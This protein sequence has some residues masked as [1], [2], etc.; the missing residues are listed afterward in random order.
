MVRYFLYSRKCRPRYCYRP[1]CCCRQRY[2]Y[3]YCWYQQRQL[4]EVCS[5][6]SRIVSPFTKKKILWHSHVAR[7]PVF[8]VSDNARH[9]PGCTG[10][11]M[12]RG[13]K[14]RSYEVSCY[15]YVAKIKALIS[16]TVTAQLISAF[17]FFIFKRQV[18]SGRGSII[19]NMY[20]DI[21]CHLFSSP[22]P[23][24]Y[25]LA[26]YI[27]MLW[28]PSLLLLSSTIFKHIFLRNSM[29]N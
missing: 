28:R 1:R 21:Y 15:I 11:M 23:K 19:T 16:C 10:H 5:Q 27:P 4:P 2:C 12:A 7:K 22:E 17:V 13:L 8:G 26:Y 24:A 20:N 18:F 14:F 9:K 3:R 29:A 25:R 6:T